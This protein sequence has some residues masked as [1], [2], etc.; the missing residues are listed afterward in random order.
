MRY[1]V[2]KKNHDENAENGVS[3]L[4]QVDFD[5]FWRGDASRTPT[6]LPHLSPDDATF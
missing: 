6:F 3:E 1:F 5:I 2:R 4:L